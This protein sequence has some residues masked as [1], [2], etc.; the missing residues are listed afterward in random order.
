MIITY[1][2]MAAQDK[3]WKLKKRRKHKFVT[4]MKSSGKNYKIIKPCT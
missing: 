4:K 3:V 1:R 2:E